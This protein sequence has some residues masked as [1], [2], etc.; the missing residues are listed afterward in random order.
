MDG[1]YNAVWISDVHLCSRGC[2]AAELLR[3][4]RRVRCRYLYLV[5]DIIDL[6][7][8]KRRRYWSQAINN[9]IRSLLGQ[10]KHG[11]QVIYIPGNHDEGM[12]EFTGA[13][14]GN[15]RLCARAFHT[16]ANGRRY[17]V[18]HGHQFDPSLRRRWLAVLG[19]ALHDYLVSLER[20]VNYPL[21][22]L[23]L[24]Q[25]HVS[26]PIKRRVDGAVAAAGRF[27]EQALARARQVGADGV[28]CG[29]TH[30]P[31]VKQVDG[32][33]YCN[34]GD[35]TEHCTAVVE[36]LDGELRLLRWVDE[37]AEPLEIELQTA[38]ARPERELAPVA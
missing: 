10:T 16:A 5:G 22:W 29:H 18:T 33:R 19:A 8:F 37:S 28:I 1:R 23:R 26:G 34:T 25:L 15:I 30:A 11:T 3:F 32:L 9:V 20:L 38:P 6:W 12:R 13:T 14:F 17:L 31:A 4:V 35:W 36:T 27:E 24:P 2:R 21:R 7:L